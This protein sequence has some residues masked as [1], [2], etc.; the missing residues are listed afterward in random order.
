VVGRPHDEDDD[1]V[2][3][4]RAQRGGGSPP[5]DS[6][7]VRRAQRGDLGAYEQI[8]VRHQQTAF[9]A[10][11]V[12]TRNAADAQDAA[13]EAFVKAYAALGRFDAERPLRP[14]LLAIV[15]NQARNRRRSEG[16]REHLATRAAA[17]VS[18]EA[19]P[20][21]EAVAVRSAE[22]AAL[23]E[24][25]VGLPERDRTLIYLRY[26]LDLSE[27]ETATA[28]GV[29]PGTVKS[30]TSRALARLRTATEARDG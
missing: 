25:V 12:V 1:A 22:A 18:G 14:W 15:V 24:L 19:A 20:S 30:R 29:R 5:D 21:P 11:Q 9:R 7:L 4:R 16:R 27:E 8:V 3:T 13:Q 26:F 23:R 10:A 6:E 17:Q 2:V 28:L